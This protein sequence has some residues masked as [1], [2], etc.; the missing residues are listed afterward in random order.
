M[1]NLVLAVIWLLFALMAFALPSLNPAMG[2]WRI[3]GTE[4]SVGW[5]G[6]ALCVYNL[7]RW[8][9]TR[10]STPERIPLRTMRRRRDRDEEPPP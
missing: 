8:W 4:W 3:P 10:G 6:V 7:V 5:F 1:F 9:A 2:S